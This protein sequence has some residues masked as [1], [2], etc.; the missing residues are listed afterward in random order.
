MAET[1]TTQFG[2]RYGSRLEKL[3]SEG[4]GWS[5]HLSDGSVHH[6]DRVVRSPRLK[7]KATGT[8]QGTMVE[9]F[10]TFEVDVARHGTLL[11]WMEGV[12]QCGSSFANNDDFLSSF[13]PT[14]WCD[15][16]E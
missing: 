16:E 6:G 12:G 7:R 1:I 5:C 11:C 13:V 14:A 15:N 9:G 4:Q 8:F 2:G 10:L 3:T